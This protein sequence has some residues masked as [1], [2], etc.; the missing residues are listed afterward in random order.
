MNTVMEWNSDNTLGVQ[1]VEVRYYRNKEDGS[2]WQAIQSL[3]KGRFYYQKSNK[4]GEQIAK[5][6]FAKPA[7]LEGLEPCEVKY[8]LPAINY[9]PRPKKW[10]TNVKLAQVVCNSYNVK[11][12][13]LQTKVHTYN[14]SFDPD[15]PA[16]N[17]TERQNIVYGTNYSEKMS[18][19]R[20]LEKIFGRFELDNTKFYSVGPKPPNKVTLKTLSRG[21]TVIFEYQQTESLD[22]KV[23]PNTR[24]EQLLNIF[25]R[26]QMRVA[27]Y[28]KLHRGWFKDS[29]NFL[30]DCEIVHSAQGNDLAILR[31]FEG[32]MKHS[33]FVD[34][35]ATDRNQSPS[36]VVFQCDLSHKL[37]WKHTLHEQMLKLKSACTEEKDF[38][39]KA[40]RTF[41][42]KFFILDYSRRSMCISSIDWN[43]N[44]ISPLGEDN[45]LTYRNYLKQRYNINSPL[46]EMCVVKTRDGACFLPQHM[47]LTVVSDEC[48][49]MYE[50]AM[51]KINCPIHIRMNRL[52]K[53][54]EELN[55]QRS[56]KNHTD[57]GGGDVPLRLDFSIE[58]KGKTIPAMLLDQPK[59]LFMTKGGP[60]AF[61]VESEFSSSTWGRNCAGYMGKVKP[62]KK[63]AVI[64]DT[65]SRFVPDAFMDAFSHYCR[66]RGF[67]LRKRDQWSPPEFRPVN[68][69][70]HQ[71]YPRYIKPQDQFLVI[72]LPDGIKG[73]EVKV[74]FSKSAQMGQTSKPVQVQFCLANNVRESTKLFGVLENMAVKFGNVLYRV[75]PAL[76][77][78]SVIKPEV[79]WVGG[80]DVSHNGANNPSVCV[81]TM[82]HD[83]F[84][85]SQK[86]IHHVWHP[87][88][89]RT[90]IIPYKRI[91]NLMYA[92]L[93][94]SFEMIGK[95]EKL[96]PE[97]IYFFRDGVSD[98]QIREMH[99]K[100]LNGIKL[101]IRT[102]AR[103]SQKRKIK[104]RKGNSVWNPKIVYIVVQKNIL[105]RFGQLEN[106]ML[107]PPKQAA[108]IFDYVLSHRIWDFVA[109]FNT[110]G[111]NRPLRYIVVSDDM[112]LAD[113]GGGVDLFNFVYALCWMYAY[114]VP[115][116][117]GNPNQPAPI[118]YAKHFAEVI[119][120]QILS[121]DTGF[122]S[123]KTD[124]SLNRPHLVT[125]DCMTKGSRGAKAAAPPRSAAAA[126][127]PQS[128]S[129]RADPTPTGPPQA[130]TWG[131]QP[132]DYAGNQPSANNGA[133]QPQSN[134]YH[135]NHRSNGAPPAQPPVNGYGG[136]QGRGHRSGPPPSHQGGYQPHHSYGAAPPHGSPG[137]QHYP[138]QH[139]GYGAPPP[140]HH[141]A[142]QPAV[143][144]YGAPP[145]GYGGQGGYAPQN[146]W[147]H[148]PAHG[149]PQHGAPQHSPYGSPHQ[150]PMNPRGSPNPH[151]NG[152]PP[153]APWG[154]PN[155]RG[156]GRG[157]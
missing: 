12:R 34:S 128:S 48:K 90:E 80:I 46:R 32:N 36:G 137:P 53:F 156:R 147:G 11:G 152:A 55:R 24:Q 96:L 98:G 52:D 129:T 120:Q 44:E 146:S 81:L 15:V 83:P 113:N 135:P 62:M 127:P 22:S 51:N 54:V 69:D 118:K 91:C 134:N 58:S 65:R 122:E 131:H 101:A 14:I 20:E 157:Y 9:A 102:W 35:S 8:M 78:D 107:R 89:P 112:K 105:D 66:K 88:P 143:G 47:R 33:A 87:N 40:E 37:L 139:G 116:P 109:W 67:D 3:S 42:G 138:P 125:E 149:A 45:P 13:L 154:Q 49:D 6:S 144:K 92:A 155:H 110:R 77:E 142:R 74:R 1:Q 26:D 103:T 140:Q 119:S 31:G 72:C 56:K 29:N 148:P 85:G 117:L 94:R 97:A 21:F 93:E 84:E 7:E 64:F 16:A 28:K 150:Y 10:P 136:G 99:S 100:E 19:R 57:D 141:H 68:L 95:N 79:S 76:R 75:L 23:I 153:N 121:T 124:K 50:S 41:V 70:L 132:N 27:R 5:P 145:P 114:S 86:N 60:Q 133:A 123:L 130:K 63:W 4:D 73:S 2:E 17:T 126:P 61:A 106:G 111:K 108:V 82:M 115:F 59:I 30:D 18:N 38:K 151:H 43:Q 104:N 39:I 25:H 71:D